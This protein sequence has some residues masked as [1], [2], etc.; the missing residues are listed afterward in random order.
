MFWD[1]QSWKYQIAITECRYYFGHFTIMDQHL[2][3]VVV[4]LNENAHCGW[5][6]VGYVQP[7]PEEIERKYIFDGNERRLITVPNAF[8]GIEF[9]NKTEA[10]L[11]KMVLNDF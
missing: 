10:V 5:R 7:K 11:F 1:L 6:C 8:L 4:W 9:K 3:P 2:S